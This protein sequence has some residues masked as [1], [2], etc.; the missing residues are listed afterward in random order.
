MQSLARRVVDGVQANAPR[1]LCFACLAGQQRVREHDVR[2]VALV[3]VARAGIHLTRRVCSSCCRESEV[4]V[5]PEPSE[6]TPT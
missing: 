2:G 3:L 4:I 1:A 5:P 6:K